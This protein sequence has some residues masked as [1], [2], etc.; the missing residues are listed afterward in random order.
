[1]TAGTLQLEDLVARASAG[2]TETAFMAALAVLLGHASPHGR[3][4]PLADALAR[5]GRETYRGIDWIVDP[6]EGSSANVVARSVAGSAS[7][8]LTLYCHL[9]TSLTGEM[10]VDRDITADTGDPPGFQLE[11]ITRS[12]RGFGVGVAKA[13]AAAAIVAFTSASAALRERAIGHR[14]TLLLAACG[15]H[16]AAPDGARR[17]FGEGVRHAL[18]KGWR[19]DAVLNTKA[20]P[21][22]VLY[23]EPAAAYLEVRL[24]R[25]WTAALARRDAAPDGG[26]LRQTGAVVDAIEAWRTRYL[27]THPATGQLA[28]EIAIG[29][30]RGGSTEKPDLL[31]G[32]LR[33]S[34]YAV[35]LPEDDV[36]EAARDLARALAPTVEALPG[37]PTVSV[38]VYA[39]APGGRC[40]PTSEVVRLTTAAAARHLGDVPPIARWSGA[41]D[42]AIFLAAGIPTARCGPQ[43]SRDDRDPRVEVV[44]LDQTLAAARA[45]VDVA[46]RFCGARA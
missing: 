26:L 43:V 3:E 42:G 9:D 35:L 1:M 36:D 28:P 19:P 2:V 32:L 37:S 13:P 21:P 14:L 6:L 7:R 12:L 38:D 10:S 41:T 45:Y 27:G 20:G 11:P 5:W 33:I 4:R 23:E 16:R 18:A 30:L 34:V 46:I 8:E 31:P 17:T 40:D 24:R 44:S 29:A 39:A 15:T 22:G 25:A